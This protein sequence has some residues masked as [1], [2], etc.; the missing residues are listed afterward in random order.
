MVD[1]FTIDRVDDTYAAH[2]EIDVA[3]KTQFPDPPVV[4]VTARLSSRILKEIS[5]PETF[6]LAKAITP[7]AS[8]INISPFGFRMWMTN[9]N[10]ADYGYADFSW[11]ALSYPEP[12]GV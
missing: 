5:N 7:V 8:V 6:D 2:K 3:F 10:P 1:R 9:D 11:V 4:M 12:V